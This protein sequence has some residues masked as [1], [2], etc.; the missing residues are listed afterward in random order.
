MTADCLYAKCG[1]PAVPNRRMCV[2]HL[3]QRADEAREYRKNRKMRGICTSPGCGRRICKGSKSRC[4]GCLEA[5]RKNVSAIYKGRQRAGLC[6]R[7][8]EP[9]ARHSKSRCERHLRMAREDMAKRRVRR[10]AP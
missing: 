1:E 4:A 8:D 6:R 3:R 10:A 9:L 7:C 5:N 2:K